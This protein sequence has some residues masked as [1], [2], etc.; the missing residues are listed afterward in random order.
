MGTV[1]EPRYPGVS[2]NL[3]HPSFTSSV[4]MMNAALTIDIGDRLAINNPP[5]WLPPDQV[6]QIVQGYTETLGVFE[7]DITFNCSPES[8]YRIGILQD[9]VVGVLDTDG[10]GLVFGVSASATTLTVGT[11]A[12]GSALWTTSAG[13]FPFDITVGGERMTV[14]N[15]TGASSPQTFTVIRSINSVI[16]SQVSGTDVRLWQPM[17][18][19]L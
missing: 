5:A 16:K 18:L 1:D 4:D 6:S 7:H 19:S 12:A 13:D 11:F 10:S 8:P 3:R 2:I 14:T 17:I 15:I 9:S